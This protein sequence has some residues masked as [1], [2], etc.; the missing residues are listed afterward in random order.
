MIR[1][2]LVDD[3]AMMR[4]GLSGLLSGED[5]MQI[6]AECADG[7]VAVKLALDLGP[8]VVIMDVGL[9]SLNGIE[10]TKRIVAERPDIQVLM[11]TM[12]DD[13]QTV[14]RAL[15]AGARG[16]VLKGA[17]V[18]TLCTAIRAVGRGEVYLSEAISAYVVQGY[19]GTSAPVA[20][21]LSSRETQILQLIAEGFTSSEI[22]ERLGLK[23]K[24]IQNYRTNVM[25]KLGVKTT[26]GLVRYA[27]KS[28]LIR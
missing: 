17:G 19:L 25:D 1:L 12:Y 28:G 2:L 16:Y 18:E 22:A 14:D 6:V 10:A 24:T 23:T 3:H 15:R 20:E 13:A 26:A 27:L 4:Q 9:P 7:A 8:D 21:P 11:L 5:D